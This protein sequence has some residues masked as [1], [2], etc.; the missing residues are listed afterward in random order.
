MI[1][2]NDSDIEQ[3]NEEIDETNQEEIVQKTEISD[4]KQ[5][6]VIEV[7]NEENNEEASKEKHS[8]KAFI[9]STFI[10]I[11]IVMIVVGIFIVK[12]IFNKKQ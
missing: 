7:E 5:D 8:N 6:D 2:T 10:G 11:S 1:D 4:Q 9:Y 12:S 3:T